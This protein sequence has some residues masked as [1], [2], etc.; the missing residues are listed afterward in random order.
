MQILESRN[1]QPT[2]RIRAISTDRDLK[3]VLH[4]WC[5]TGSAGHPIRKDVVDTGCFPRAEAATEQQKR[6]ALPEE[7][8]TSIRRSTGIGLQALSSPHAA[9]SPR[10]SI[11]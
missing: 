8:G 3:I 1:L 5:E 4:S 10:K 6:T 9:N 2:L 11:Q 7:I